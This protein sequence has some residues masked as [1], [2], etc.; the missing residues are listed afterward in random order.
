M[1]THLCRWAVAAIGIVLALGSMAQAEVSVSVTLT[2]PI[3]QLLPILQYIKDLAPGAA[4][5]QE[6]LRLQLHSVSGESAPSA[7]S[8]GET[9]GQEPQAAGQPLALSIH[10]PRIEPVA[11]RPGES[12]KIS[13]RIADPDRQVDT[14][15][16]TI[17]QLDGQTFDLYDNG[18]NG[19]AQ[20]GDGI[21]SYAFTLP[22]TAAPGQYALNIVAY[23]KNG[24]P[25]LVKAADGRS[26][27][28]QA[29]APFTVNR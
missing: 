9:A 22:P 23:D 15:G 25:L 11:V 12:L 28:L 27:L 8:A 20:A 10:P 19:D 14:V 2:G 18:S 6:G 17:P 7:G 1:K 13:T 29:Q 26:R 21:W 3:D 24:T 16:V 5:S 4:G